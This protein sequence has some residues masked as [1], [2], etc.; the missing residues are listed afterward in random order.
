MGF[1]E[2]QILVAPSDFGF[3]FFVFDFFF[4]KLI[5]LHIFAGILFI[6]LF[7]RKIKMSG[8]GLYIKGLKR[9]TTKLHVLDE[10]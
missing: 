10:I 3:S 6:N 9:C 5:F 4:I 1:S 8:T 2:Y 7:I